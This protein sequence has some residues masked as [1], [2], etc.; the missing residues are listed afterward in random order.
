MR[1]RHEHILLDFLR[2]DYVINRT[3]GQRLTSSAVELVKK[4]GGC[5]SE[6]EQSIFRGSSEI[7][8]VMCSA[9]Y[10]EGLSREDFSRI[11][12]VDSAYVNITYDGGE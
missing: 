3:T 12:V 1:F 2:S 7:N 10:N 4:L 6:V 11:K 8:T 5:T 9:P